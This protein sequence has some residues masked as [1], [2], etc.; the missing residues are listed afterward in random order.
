MKLISKYLTV[1]ILLL[2][3]TFANAHDFAYT[4]PTNE[5]STENLCEMNSDYM[6][7]LQEVDNE[8]KNCNA[9]QV[10]YIT[11]LHN[12]YQDYMIAPEYTGDGL[13]ANK[14]RICA[15]VA[16]LASCGKPNFNY[17]CPPVYGVEAEF[18]VDLPA[19]FCGTFE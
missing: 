10:M 5:P 9:R 17:H 12:V 8:F 18:E 14:N 7:L 19:D 13:N 4:V 1:F 2:C 16:R 11:N 6:R 15:T 3:A